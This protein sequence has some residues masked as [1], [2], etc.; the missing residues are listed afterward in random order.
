MGRRRVAREGF[1]VAAIALNSRPA[2]LILIW[3]AYLAGSDGNG[4]VNIPIRTL[5][6]SLTLVGEGSSGGSTG[7]QAGLAVTRILTVLLSFTVLSNI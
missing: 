4:G 3:P 1:R 6:L 2:L 7:K 5:P